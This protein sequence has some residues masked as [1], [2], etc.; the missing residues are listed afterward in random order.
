MKRTVVAKWGDAPFPHRLAKTKKEHQQNLELLFAL[1]RIAF[2]QLAGPLRL[3]KHYV[4]KRRL[5]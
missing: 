2:P 5:K 4:K 1:Q 3:K